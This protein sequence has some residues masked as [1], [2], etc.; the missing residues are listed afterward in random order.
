MAHYLH[1]EVVQHCKSVKH[2]DRAYFWKIYQ[3]VGLA[4]EVSTD[5]KSLSQA[6]FEKHVSNSSKPV[7]EG[8]VDLQILRLVGY[9]YFVL[10]KRFIQTKSYSSA[11]RSRRAL[12]QKTAEGNGY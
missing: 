12:D 9:I 8:A 4:W 11:V 6:Q 1:R 2:H 7:H 5:I 10:R 3:T